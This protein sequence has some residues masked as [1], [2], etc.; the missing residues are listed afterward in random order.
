MRLSGIAALR[1]AK[2]ALG[3]EAAVALIVGVKQPSVHYMLRHG[4]RVPAEWCGPLE[5][6]T[7]ALGNPDKIVTRHQL[8]PD[9]FEG[10]DIRPARRPTSPRTAAA[11]AAR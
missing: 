4:K 11:G 9:L 3:S 5:D 7:R 2:K 1:H 8:R 6:A 10:D